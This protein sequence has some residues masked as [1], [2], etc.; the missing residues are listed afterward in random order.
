MAPGDTMGGG[1]AGTRRAAGAA[2]GGGA[3]SG[4]SSGVSSSDHLS[5]VASG[6]LRLM[7]ERCGCCATGSV[8]LKQPPAAHEWPPAEMARLGPAARARAAYCPPL[9]HQAA[10]S[11]CC[12]R[13]PSPCTS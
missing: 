12:I 7:G 5:V 1:A 11:G 6:F 8:A 13:R 9:L 3:S 2:D 10:A 4:A